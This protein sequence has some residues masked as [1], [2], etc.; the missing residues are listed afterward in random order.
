MQLEEKRADLHDPAKDGDIFQCD[1]DHRVDG[2][3]VHDLTLDC[4]WAHNPLFLRGSGALGAVNVN[5]SNVLLQNVKIVGFGTRAPKAECFPVFIYPGH[6]FN[7][8]QFHN[9]RIINCVFSNP[10]PGNRG[11]LSCAAIG[12]DEGVTMTGS[13][14]RG[15]RFLDVASDFTYSH[16]FFA[17]ECADNYVRN[18]GQAFYAEPTDKQDYTWIIRNNRF[19]NVETGAFVNWHPGAYL[20]QI[21]FEN[22][23]VELNPDLPTAA[24]VNFGEDGLDA[25]HPP[26]ILKTLTVAHNTIRLA[27]GQERSSPARGLNVVS[28]KRRFT[29]ENVVVAA[30]TFD[31][32]KSRATTLDPA[33]IRNLQVQ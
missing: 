1:Y 33:T 11:G 14:I 13:V 24:A 8:R 4:D 26:A 23:L 19:I 32:P 29:V 21:V 27:G 6:A 5:G 22:N 12:A 2:F 31:L 17:E 3:E 9:V 20:G 15:C 28:A 25:S 18:C 7:G 16:A 30:N 10:A